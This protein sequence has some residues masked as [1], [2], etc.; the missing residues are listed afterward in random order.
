MDGRFGAHTVAGPRRRRTG[1]ARRA[2]PLGP[3]LEFEKW[4]PY[5]VPGDAGSFPK[6]AGRANQNSGRYASD[7]SR[8]R[9]APDRDP[10]VEKNILPKLAST[11]TR[12]YAWQVRKSALRFRA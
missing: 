6:L 3:I 9:P 2:P 10:A 8:T 11:N 12:E 4:Y 1:D 5:F 7:V